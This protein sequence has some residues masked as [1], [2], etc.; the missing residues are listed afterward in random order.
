MNDI[1]LNLGTVIIALEIVIL[2]ATLVTFLFITKVPYVPSRKNVI[3]KVLEEFTLKKDELIYDLGCGDGRFLMAAEKKYQTIGKGFEL[4][5]LP[6]L[7]AQFTKLIKRSRNQFFLK[8]FYRHSLSDSKLIY[9][10]L[11]PNVLAQVYQKFI[12]E[13]APGS[14]LISNSFPVKNIT[15]S[16][17]INSSNSNKIYVY[18]N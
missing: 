12:Q 18:Q 10:Y 15:P 3:D 14:I 6:Y 11:Y 13:T 4:A 8:D 7:I 16:K 5:P 9:C 17:I 2:M 1:L